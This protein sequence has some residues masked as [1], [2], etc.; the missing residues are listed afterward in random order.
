MPHTSEW[1]RTAVRALERIQQLLEDQLNL[2][3][4][5][6]GYDENAAGRIPGVLATLQLELPEAL[7]TLRRNTPDAI[8][9]QRLTA[10]RQSQE[11]AYQRLHEANQNLERVRSSSKRAEAAQ[12]VEHCRQK[13]SELGDAIRELER[14]A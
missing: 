3:P 2:L 8:R 1:H 14:E 11:R 6:R 12:A 10:A 5:I 13:L 9:L 4:N 7:E